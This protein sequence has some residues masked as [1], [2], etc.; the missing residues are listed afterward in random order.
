MLYLD[1]SCHSYSAPRTAERSNPYCARSFSMTGSKDMPGIIPQ[2]NA[3]MFQRIS[4]AR[5]SN[6]DKKYLVTCSFMESE[7]SETRTGSQPSAFT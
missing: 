7:R 2:M 3:E 1:P 5:D 6:P 4:D